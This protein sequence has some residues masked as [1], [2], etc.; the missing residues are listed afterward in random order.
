VQ[1]LSC[2]LLQLLCCCPW[3]DPRCHPL[4]PLLPPAPLTAIALS[5][6]CSLRLLLLP[7]PRPPL[8]W[9]LL[10]QLLWRLLA[11]PSLT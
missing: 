2:L 9:L 6:A 8:L 5:E 4:L 10:W 1:F 3:P 11:L 7:W